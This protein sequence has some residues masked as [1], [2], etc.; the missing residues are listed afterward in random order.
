MGDPFTTEDKRLHTNFLLLKDD[1]LTSLDD[2]N[3]KVIH[4]LASIL[5]SEKRY[6]E[7]VPGS[8]LFRLMELVVRREIPT[9]DL[10]SRRCY[11]I[12]VRCAAARIFLCVFNTWTDPPLINPQRTPTFDRQLLNDVKR[13][14]MIDES[15]GNTIVDP[16][17]LNTYAIGLLLAFVGGGECFPSSAEFAELSANATDFLHNRFFGQEGLPPVVNTPPISASWTR[18]KVGGSMGVQLRQILLV[19]NTI[20]ESSAVPMHLPTDD[21]ISICAEFAANE[22]EKEAKAAKA[23]CEAI[24]FVRDEAEEFVRAQAMKAKYHASKAASVAASQVA[25]ASSNGKTMWN[26]QTKKVTVIDEAVEQCIYLS[27]DEILDLRVRFSLQCLQICG[28]VSDSRLLDL[29]SKICAYLLRNYAILKTPAML[30]FTVISCLFVSHFFVKEFMN[31]K[32][33]EELLRVGREI[34]DA[35]MILP[36]L[37]QIGSNLRT[38]DCLCSLSCDLVNEVVTM[39]LEML[40]CHEDGRKINS[41]RFLTLAFAFLK[42]LD[43]FD[44]QE[45]ITKI[46][47]FFEDFDPHGADFVILQDACYALRVYCSIKLLRHV[48]FIR[49]KNQSYQAFPEDIVSKGADVVAEIQLNE[50][51]SFMLF[52]TNNWNLVKKFE[53]TNAYSLLL[54]ASQSALDLKVHE[55]AEHACGILHIITLA[56]CSHESIMNITMKN[57]RVGVAVILD[58]TNGFRHVYP[59]A[60]LQA[61]G[62]L[63]NLTSATIS[64]STRFSD[65]SGRHKARNLI[66]VNKGL[67]ILLDFFTTGSHRKPI[68]LHLQVLACRVLICLAGDELIADMLKKLKVPEKLVS[69]IQDSY[70]SEADDTRERWRRELK[71]LSADLISIITNAASES[72]I[73][74]TGETTPITFDP[75]DLLCLVHEYLRASGL[76]GAATSLETE[77]N[78]A[79]L[80]LPTSQRLTLDSIMV[81]YLRL[82]HDHCPAPLAT[83]PPQSLLHPHKCSQLKHNFDSHTNLTLRMRRRE[84]GD[85]HGGTRDRIEDRRYI[86]SR[87]GL[88][89][90]IQQSASSFTCLNFSGRS[91]DIVVGSVDGTLRTF[92]LNNRNMLETSNTTH[93]TPVRSVR[94]ALVGDRHF[95]LSSATNEVCLWNASPISAGPI[96]VLEGC[97]SASFSSSGSEFAAC[98]TESPL[99]LCEILIYDSESCTMKQKL[100]A[101]IPGLLKLP[102]YN[103]HFSPTDKSILWN[104][105]LWDPRS[106]IPIHRFDEL[107]DYGGGGFHPYKSEIILNSEVWDTRNLKL[108]HVVPCLDQTN[109]A[110]DGYAGILYATSRMKIQN[111]MDLSNS[112]LYSAFRSI[113]LDTYTSIKTLDVHH[114]V[115]DFAVDTTY[116]RVGLVTLRNNDVNSGSC[117]KLYN[118]GEPTDSEDMPDLLE[119]YLDLGE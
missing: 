95:L 50:S 17:M 72:K 86:Y 119:E 98:C 21:S 55:L 113:D 22:A 79:P 104:G 40:G 71:A 88:C 3:P 14:I 53:C 106:P 4:A 38:M 112:E 96:H 47:C 77:A 30:I 69:L 115:L 83:L 28:L 58:V 66:R 100:S 19:R 76:N 111:S 80:P 99:A 31:V 110:F 24:Q 12:S 90:T 57:G 8:R 93:S 18:V 116:S 41:L 5:E 16:V 48:D 2:P 32:G 39:M 67:G 26:E 27:R 59:Q 45:G 108:L 105:I 81:E 33:I 51:L 114:C 92:D 75:G 70:S 44:A 37:D 15:H 1:I 46:L 49:Q 13:W 87:F 52:T 102:D 20:K 117:V 118:I 56:P 78:L 25:M 60:S 54:E 9:H 7:E 36:I 84:H 91:S 11:S 89:G 6:R 109:I 64:F 63:R 68:F 10:L 43:A 101:D 85:R 29:Q 42:T 94:S 107:T 74:A 35:K 82:K 97:S 23:S 61:L 73:V 34:G 65:T 62:I 103:I